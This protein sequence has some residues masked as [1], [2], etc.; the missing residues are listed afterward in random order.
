MRQAR[1]F[2][3]ALDQLLLVNLSLAP[4]SFTSLNLSALYVPG[5]RQRGSQWPTLSDLEDTF[6]SSIKFGCMTQIYRLSV[7]RMCM[8]DNR[9]PAD[10]NHMAG[11]NSALVVLLLNNRLCI[12]R[13][14]DAYM[15]VANIQMRATCRQILKH[16]D[17]R[18]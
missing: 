6:T 10:A 4:V 17:V 14:I 12:Y 2:H 3:F 13:G 15:M 1:N 9:L 7:R 18:S 5:A 16:H 8:N 11:F